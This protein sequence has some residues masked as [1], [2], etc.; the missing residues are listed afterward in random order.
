DTVAIAA[1]IGVVLGLIPVAHLVG[2][3]VAA[4]LTEQGRST[5]G[6]RGARLV[7]R[8]FVVVQVAFAFVLLVGAGLLL[9]SFRRVLAVD[10]G[11]RADGV[12]TA[13]ISLPRARYS[14]EATAAFTNE[15][16]RRLRVLPGIAAAGATDTIPFGANNNDSV[17]FA[18]G[19]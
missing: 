18:E 16:L 19:Y 12:L 14:D 7:R 1:G 15:A 3:N 5:A 4:V 11:F 17:I 2:V 8:A 10:P 6:G 13:S 9:T